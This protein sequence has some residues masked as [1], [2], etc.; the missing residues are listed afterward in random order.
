MLTRSVS[1]CAQWKGQQRLKFDKLHKFISRQLSIG[2]LLMF[3]KPLL[4]FFSEQLSELRKA[5]VVK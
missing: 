2:F 5:A 1:L 3:R 4:C